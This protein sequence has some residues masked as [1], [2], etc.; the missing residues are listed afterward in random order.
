MERYTHSGKAHT[1][2]S[3]GQG[4]KHTTNLFTVRGISA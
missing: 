3:R 1:L 4:G 2:R